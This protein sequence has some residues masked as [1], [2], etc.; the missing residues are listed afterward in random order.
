MPRTRHLAEML[1]AHINHIT[2][3]QGDVGNFPF[4]DGHF[5]AI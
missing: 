5:P 2:T 4:E 3:M 1:D